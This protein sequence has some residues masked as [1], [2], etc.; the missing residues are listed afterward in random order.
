VLASPGGCPE[1]RLLS[2]DWVSRLI[3]G[4]ITGLLLAV[5]GYESSERQPVAPA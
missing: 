2:K 5:L 1:G 3:A 4:L